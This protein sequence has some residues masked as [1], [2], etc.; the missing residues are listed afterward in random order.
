MVYQLDPGETAAL[1]SSGD[2]HLFWSPAHQLLATQNNSLRLV[3]QPIA[4]SDREL[5]AAFYSGGEVV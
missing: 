1:H 2:I 5:A 3:L 4:F